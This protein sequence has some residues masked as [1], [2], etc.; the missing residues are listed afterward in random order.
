MH[1]DPNEPRP[2]RYWC[3]DESRFGLHTIPRRRLNATGIKPIGPLQWNYQAYYLYGLV[4]PATG[5][6]F[7]LEF[8]HSD[9]TCFQCFLDHFAARYP[10]E[11]HVL[12]LDRASFHQAQHL[13]IPENVI[14]LYQPPKCPELNPI[15]RLWQHLKDK[16]SWAVFD[17]LDA[18]RAVLDQR[19]RELT[20]AVVASL[21]GFD[22]IIKA[23]EFAEFY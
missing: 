17:S 1:Q 22:F 20:P 7:V 3:G 5:E 12:Q 10:H 18:L 13:S 4:E 23:L 9:S 6:Q 11:L 2:V 15:E 19:L 21:T 8:S 14:L 16:L